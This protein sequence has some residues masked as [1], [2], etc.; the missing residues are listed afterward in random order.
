MSEIKIHPEVASIGNYLYDL[1]QVDV[2]WQESQQ[3]F[4]SK[5]IYVPQPTTID[6]SDTLS[7][8]KKS[9]NL[10]VKIFDETSSLAFYHADR[11]A[12]EIR[13]KR[14]IIPLLGVGGSE[15]GDYVRIK[16]IEA[17]KSEMGV[18]VLQITWDSRYLYERPSYISLE[19]VE[20]KSEVRE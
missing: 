4:G 9:Y 18:A 13:M 12:D 15:T 11:L 2:F 16:S 3:G 7:S 20:F 6:S 8:F 17:R 10:G 5:A 14:G 19:E 1:H